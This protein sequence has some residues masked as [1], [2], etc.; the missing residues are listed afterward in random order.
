MVKAR[1]WSKPEHRDRLRA[2]SPRSSIGST[3]SSL[4]LAR[5]PI[6][7]VAWAKRSWIVNVLA[8]SY[9]PFA[10]SWNLAGYP[11]AAPAVR[12]A[13]GRD[14]PRRSSCRPRGKGAAHSLGGPSAR[15]AAALAPPSP[16]RRPIGLAPIAPPVVHPAGAGSS[17]PPLPTRQSTGQEI[18]VVDPHQPTGQKYR[19]GDRQGAPPRRVSPTGIMCRSHLPGD[20][21]EL[22]DSAERAWL[23]RQA[24]PACRATRSSA[25]CRGGSNIENYALVDRVGVAWWSTGAPRISAGAQSHQWSF[26]VFPYNAKDPRAGEVTFGR[27]SDHVVVPDP[28]SSNARSV[29]PAGAKRAWVLHD[30]LLQGQPGSDVRDVGA[31]VDAVLARSG[32]PA[33]GIA[34]PREEVEPAVRT[35]HIE[36]LGEIRAV[37]PCAGSL[38]LAGGDVVTA[39]GAL[40]EA[41]PPTHRTSP[42][43]HRGGT[44]PVAKGPM[45][46]F[47][48]DLWQ[49][50]T[51][52]PSLGSS[53]SPVLL[54]LYRILCASSSACSHEWASMTQSWRSPCCATS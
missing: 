47:K 1:G 49:W 20:N 52:M 32:T 15:G 30:R 35:V 16:D 4:R 11:A 17:P 44:A 31:R 38:A 27:Y 7:A 6:K 41:F 53:D 8:N 10:Q 51:G 50:S 23:S 24:T 43:R 28:L 5:P 3:W 37:A 29:V 2:A 13:L 22:P 34:L 9:A 36:G 42:L 40:P 14:S 12:D 19:D 48:R 54:L 26:P 46:L 25:S 39:A 45:P 33:P 18:H 21:D